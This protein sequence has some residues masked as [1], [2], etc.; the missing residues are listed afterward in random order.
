MVSQ[1][2]SALISYRLKK[3]KWSCHCAG[4]SAIYGCH[5]DTPHARLHGAD[6]VYFRRRTH[7]QQH[8][9]GWKTQS[10]ACIARI[11]TS[12][13]A[14]PVITAVPR[15]TPLLSVGNHGR[16]QLGFRPATIPVDGGEEQL[17]AMYP[18]RWKLALRWWCVQTIERRMHRIF[19]QSTC[20]VLML[21]RI[22]ALG[23]VVKL[24]RAEAIT[25]IPQRREL[26]DTSVLAEIATDI[27][28]SPQPCSS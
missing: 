26:C 27:W 9:H 8:Y 14:S 6:G 28:N 7:E 2:C 23:L 13:R 15:M 22:V 16:Y 25:S 24:R 1:G 21:C 17:I 3:A 12:K 4:G 11:C 5:Q 18:C 10:S 20:H 19:P